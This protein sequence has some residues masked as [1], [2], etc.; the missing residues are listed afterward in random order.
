[1]TYIISDMAK[2]K[3]DLLNKIADRKESAPA[4]RERGPKTLYLNLET[5]SKFKKIIS[6]LS[7]SI[8]FDEFM[9]ETIKGE[10][11]KK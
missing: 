11:K 8:A 3:S 1:M 9:E 7:P 4:E 6:P 2:F 10:Q 5:F